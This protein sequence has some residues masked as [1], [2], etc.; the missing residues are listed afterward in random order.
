VASRQS[1]PLSHFSISSPGAYRMG[2]S[3]LISRRVRVL[4]GAFKVDFLLEDEAVVVPSSLAFPVIS[5]VKEGRVLSRSCWMS[6]RDNER[7]VPS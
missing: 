6:F 3:S 1:K 2:V 7:P 4:G 5:F